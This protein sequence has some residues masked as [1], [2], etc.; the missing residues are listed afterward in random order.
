MPCVKSVGRYR[1]LSGTLVKCQKVTQLVRRHCE[2]K[3]GLER[4]SHRRNAL[5]CEMPWVNLKSPQPSDNL[6][7]VTDFVIKIAV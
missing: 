6:N 4:N 7:R 1:W 2:S 5:C 3:V